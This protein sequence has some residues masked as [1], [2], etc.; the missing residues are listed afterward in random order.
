MTAFFAAEEAEAQGL[1]EALGPLAPLEAPI[2]IWQGEGVLL[3]ET[4]VGK[5]AAASAVAYALARF[6]LEAGFFLGVAG[7]LDPGLRALDF[8]LAERAVQWDVDLTP[9]GRLPG[10][11]AL[12]VR[13]FFSHPGLLARAEGALRALG[14]PYRLGAVATGDRFVAS[15]QEKERLRALFGA[16]AV[17]M[18]GA[19]ALMVAQRFGLPLALVRVV[20]DAAGEGAAGDFQAFLGEASRRLGL[21][22]QALLGRYGD[23]D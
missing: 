10:E 11:T 19:A 15:T 8:L 1:R 3:V 12:G 20:T 23:G 9:F 17:E 6:P 2:P 7:G 14:F 4:G 18:E 5:V 13:D 22:A 21:L 16:Q